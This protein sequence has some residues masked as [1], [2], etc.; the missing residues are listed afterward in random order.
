[1]LWRDRR[2]ARVVRA[3]A[4]EPCAPAVPSTQT[5]QALKS[6]LQFIRHGT[7]ERTGGFRVIE[8]LALVEEAQENDL[9]HEFQPRHPWTMSLHMMLLGP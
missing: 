6:R 9:K 7:V 8:G 4:Y 3:V 2:L 5:S 1:M